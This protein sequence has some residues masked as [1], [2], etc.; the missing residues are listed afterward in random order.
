MHLT[1]SLYGHSSIHTRPYLMNSFPPIGQGPHSHWVLGLAPWG[2][3]IL[4]GTRSHALPLWPWEFGGPSLWL[5][6]FVTVASTCCKKIQT[7][8]CDDL[9]HKITWICGS[10]T[11]G[12]SHGFTCADPQVTQTH[13]QPYAGQCSGVARR[14]T[15]P[16]PSPLL[17]H[18]PALFTFLEKNTYWW[19]S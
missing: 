4:K 9:C 19:T 14:L 11:Y 13:A 2:Y 12:F 8:I 15:C 3:R 5:L 18:H 10:M 17:S 16:C 6:R 7:W 1:H